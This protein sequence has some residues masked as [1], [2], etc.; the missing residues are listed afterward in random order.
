MAGNGDAKPV[1]KGFCNERS[2]AI[3]GDMAE[4]KDDLRRIYER[5]NK[6]FMAVIGAG[7]SVIIAT[8][9]LLLKG[10]S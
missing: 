2:G 1:D 9:A 10:C 4:I 3:K 7:F 5:L 8:V 6:L